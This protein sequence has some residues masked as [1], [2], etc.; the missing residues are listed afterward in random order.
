MMKSKQKQQLMNYTKWEE[1][2]IALYSCPYNVQWRTKDLESGYISTWDGEWYYH[3]KDR[4]YITIEWLEIKVETRE[5]RDEVIIILRN[6]H[7]PGVASDKVIRVY[8]YVEV[9]SFMDYL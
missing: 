6:I 3:F 9:G 5:I 8:G 7:V 2:R 4:E 1:I